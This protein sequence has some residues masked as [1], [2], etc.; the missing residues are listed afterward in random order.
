M[1]SYFE[2]ERRRAS[3]K[4][5]LKTA[6]GEYAE[7]LEGDLRDLDLHEARLQKHLAEQDAAYAFDGQNAAAETADQLAELRRAALDHRGQP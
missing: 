1:M 2:I 5:A 7:Q 3:A 4:L 6:N